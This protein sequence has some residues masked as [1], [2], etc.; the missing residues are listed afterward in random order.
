MGPRP[1]L[2]WPA[3]APIAHKAR[4]FRSG[5]VYRAARCA[6]YARVD[7]Q[8]SKHGPML[9]LFN[10]GINVS[11]RT[12]VPTY[13]PT[14]VP[15]HMCTCLQASLEI[16]NAHVLELALGATTSFYLPGS[17]PPT[18]RACSL[19]V[20]SIPRWFQGRNCVLQQS[21]SVSESVSE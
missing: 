20:C 13:V 18:L 5:L 16:L 2:S 1:S 14:N 21:E 10:S 8:L 6:G 4:L 19:I 9:S 12:Y 3:L 15:A 11:M 7:M 17:Y